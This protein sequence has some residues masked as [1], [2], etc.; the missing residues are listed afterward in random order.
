M[1]T[2]ERA[3]PAVDATRGRGPMNVHLCAVCGLLYDE[4]A[5]MPEHGI[6]QGTRWADVPNDWRCPECNVGKADFVLMDI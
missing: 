1:K 3:M 6:A 2:L 4:E 5:G